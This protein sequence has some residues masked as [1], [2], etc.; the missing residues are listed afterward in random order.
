MSSPKMGRREFAVSTAIHTIP[1]SQPQTDVG[2]VPDAAFTA[3]ALVLVAA[4]SG[5]VWYLV[6]SISLHLMTGH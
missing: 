5:G 4:L 1:A 6:W 3:R 2:S